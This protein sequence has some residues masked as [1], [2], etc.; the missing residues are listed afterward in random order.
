[1]STFMWAPF[2]VTDKANF[3]ATRCGI[4]QLSCNAQELTCSN[5]YQSMQCRGARGST[6]THLAGDMNTSAGRM[7]LDH[8]HHSGLLRLHQS[9][10]VSALAVT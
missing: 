4:H 6:H 10:P 8:V 5:G 2:A 9:T 1:M 3:D 7:H